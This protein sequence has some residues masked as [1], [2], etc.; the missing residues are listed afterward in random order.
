MPPDCRSWQ[1]PLRQRRWEMSRCRCWRPARPRRSPRRAPSSIDPY[2][3]PFS[4]PATWTPG[5]G[6]PRAFSS[7]A[8]FFMPDTTALKHLTD[9]W[10][11]RAADRLAENQLSLLRYRSNLLGA[12]L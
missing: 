7:T 3:Q 12:D 6:R 9:L 4:L 2:P 11:D 10:D 5:I 1:G 8:D